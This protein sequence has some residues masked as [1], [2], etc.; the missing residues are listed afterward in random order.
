[1]SPT[2]GEGGHIGF[3]AGPC[4]RWHDKFLYPRY[5]LNQLMEFHETCMDISLGQALE[6]TRFWC[7]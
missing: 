1:M 4:R 3:S 7:P 2:K 5:L 6:L